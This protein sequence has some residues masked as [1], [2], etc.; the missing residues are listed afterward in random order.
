MHSDIEK[1]T[2]RCNRDYQNCLTIT[3]IQ[4]SRIL[5]RRR[6][7]SDD[8]CAKEKRRCDNTLGS[9]GGRKE[10]KLCEGKCCEE[11]MCNLVSRLSPVN[12]VIVLEVSLLVTLILW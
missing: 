9:R 5:T 11:Y 8:M 7:A 1:Y 12:F 3:I 2:I 10:A 6:C 4:G